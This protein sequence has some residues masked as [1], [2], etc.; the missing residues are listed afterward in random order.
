MR[1]NTTKTKGQTQSGCENKREINFFWGLSCDRNMSG[2]SAIHRLDRHHGN[3]P[4]H[5]SGSSIYGCGWSLAISQSTLGGV[6]CPAH[7]PV[8]CSEGTRAKWTMNGSDG[9]GLDFQHRHVSLIPTRPISA[10]LVW[11]DPIEP[12]WGFSWILSSLHI[13]CYMYMYPN[14]ST[15]RGNYFH[16]SATNILFCMRDKIDSSDLWYKSMSGRQ[17]GVFS[18]Y[19][20]RPL[21]G[22]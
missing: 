22:L 11:S 10:C 17:F 4:V 21:L 12:F 13:Q 5:I 16:L 2:T 7:K 6:P 14:M 9:W 3:H 1:E 8:L 20:P 19:R 15:I 18:L